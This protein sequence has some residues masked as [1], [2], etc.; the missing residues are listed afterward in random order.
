LETSPSPSSSWL[1]KGLLNNREVVKK[2]ACISISNG[3]HVDV[4][5]S[6][7]IP[8]LPNF[9]P[10]P[11]VNLP[12]LPGTRIWN[13]LLLEDLLDPF[14]VECILSIH[15]PFSRN[16]DKWF[17][18]PASSCIFSVKSAFFVACSTLG[19]S[20]SFP[21]EIWHKFWDLKIQARLKHLLWKIAWNILPSRANIGRFVVSIVDG[22]WQ[23]PFC[24]GPLETLSHIFLEC[25]LSAFLWNSSHWP[26]C[27]VGFSNR[28]ISDW[29][30]AIIFPCEKLAIHFHDAR[31]FQLFA[32]ITMDLIWFSRNRLIHDTVIPSPSKILH[33]ILFTL[34]KHIL[35]WKDK[36][37]PSLWF[38]P[39]LGSFKGNFDVTIRG[40]FSIA[41]ATI[42]D[43]FGSIILAATQHLYSSDVL[44]GEASTALLAIQLAATLGYVDIILER[45]SML[46]ILAL[47]SSTFF[48]SWCF[49]NI[50][51]NTSV[52][53]SSFKSWKAL[54][55]FRSANFR[56]HAL[57]KWAAT[58]H[59]FSSIPKGSPI[60]SSVRI[61]SGKDPS[62]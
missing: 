36:S 49:C 13:K 55:V 16:F 2:G 12:D 50:I 54:K 11:N 46:V 7:W 20:S 25:D 58:N 26:N 6:H 51:S 47:N 33:Q 43:S 4:W 14:S 45:D 9:R 34:D 1:W 40:S 5:S 10:R 8:L 38:P 18:A 27:Y 48:G 62:L 35:A 21:A 37:S 22:A 15:L 41:A 28:P 19:R 59:V 31:R 57:G 39:L 53:L 23:C 17:R 56:A 29:V 42:S 44:L 30:L 32:S 60:L 61:Q 52:L 24:K 3:A